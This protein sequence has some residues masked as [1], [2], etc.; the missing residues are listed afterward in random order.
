MSSSTPTPGRGS[1]ADDGSRFTVED[2]GSTTDAG[3]LAHGD[4]MFHN[5]TGA[6]G[7][8]SA[9][10]VDE[11]AV[12]SAGGFGLTPATGGG[13]Q[14]L[15]DAGGSG[16]AVAVS[17]TDEAV[18]SGD[19]DSGLDRDRD[20]AAESDTPSGSGTTSGAGTSNRGGGLAD[21]IG[22]DSIGHVFDQTNGVIDG[23][24]GDSDGTADSDVHA[25]AERADENPAFEQFA[26]TE[27]SS[28]AGTDRTGAGN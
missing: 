19:R 17:S 6:G 16:R 28:S 26:D 3:T 9:D 5:D 18:P 1:D 15:P 27:G 12:G 13:R 2:S 23:L 21:L 8:G 24:D 25:A 20:V 11:G 7:R 14:D 10:V 4:T 22:D